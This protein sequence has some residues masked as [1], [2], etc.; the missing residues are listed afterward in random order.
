MSYFSRLTEIVTCNVRELVRQAE[1]PQSAIRDIINEMQEGL[2]GAQRSVQTAR[3]AEVRLEGELAQYQQQS[4]QWTERA[5]DSLKAQDE[6]AARQHLVRKREVDDLAA[7][8]EQQFRAAKSTSEHLAMTLRALEARLAEALRCQ[9]ELGLPD[10]VAAPHPA[11]GAQLHHHS[12]AERH[13]AIDAEL[14][15]LRR[16]L[17]S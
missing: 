15:A 8:L 12:V 7:A 9:Q 16:E 4:A 3:N 13:S 11:S 2:A 14:Q 5:R 17:E 1:D 6:A 10:P